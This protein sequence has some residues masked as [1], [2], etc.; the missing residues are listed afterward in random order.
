MITPIFTL[1]IM[2]LISPQETLTEFKPERVSKSATF[3]CNGK[4]ENVFPLFGPI[5]E[6]DW[7]DGWNP[8]IL[9]STNNHA[10]VE[11]HMIFQTKGHTG[12]EKY[13]WAITKFQPEHHFIEY[14][15]STSER[16]WFISVVCK[17]IR[18]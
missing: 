18:E 15:V 6:M 16:I 8:E 11:E 1:L 9:Y 4:I 14:T 2:T 7:A 13:T 17:S 5:R 12:E 10:L 3:G